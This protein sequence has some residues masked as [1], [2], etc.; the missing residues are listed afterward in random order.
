LRNQQRLLNIKQTK[1]QQQAIKQQQAEQARLQRMLDKAA[2][3]AVAAENR[4]IRA[5]AK[6]RSVKQLREKR[7]IEAA[8]K[9]QKLV[10]GTLPD[11]IM[12]I[13]QYYNAIVSSQPVTRDEA[14]AAL[15]LTASDKAIQ[16]QADYQA[17]VAAALTVQ[18]P[19]E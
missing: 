13:R 12:Y 8:E 9:Y 19:L 6:A 5:A 18:E 1:A 4:A 7:L 16:S 11:A 10:G 2:R 17:G 3:Q 15:L 14:I